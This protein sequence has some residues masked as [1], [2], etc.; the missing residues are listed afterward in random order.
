MADRKQTRTG[1]PLTDAPFKPVDRF[2]DRFEIEGSI[3]HGGFV[4]NCRPPARPKSNHL[5]LG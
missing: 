5:I 4:K 3:R 2:Q 1:E